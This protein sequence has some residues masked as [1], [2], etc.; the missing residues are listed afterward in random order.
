MIRVYD[1]LSDCID[2]FLE[3]KSDLYRDDPFTL[4]EEK[5]ELVQ[6][7][8]Q[9]IEQDY[10]QARVFLCPGLARMIGFCIPCPN[11]PGKID[12]FFGLWETVNSL[13]V[14]EM[15]FTEL[16]TWAQQQ[17][18]QT[19]VGPIDFTTAHHYRLNL[20][21]GEDRPFYQEPHQKPYYAKLLEIAGYKLQHRYYTW[22]APLEGLA[23]KFKPYVEPI[24][25]TQ[26]REHG[27]RC[28]PLGEYAW[29]DNLHRIRDIA[30]Q[31]FANN[32]NYT[33]FA[34]TYIDQ[35]LN[36]DYF[37]Q[38]CPLSS[39]IALDRHHNLVGFFLAMPDYLEH[40]QQQPTTTTTHY[41]FTTDF[42]PHL[43]NS[44]TT[45]LGKTGGVLPAYRHIGL[46]TVMS[47]LIAQWGSPYYTATGA[48]MVHERNPSAKV[49]SLAFDNNSRREYG[50]YEINFGYR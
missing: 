23:E 20:Q 50:L 41:Q 4:P 10:H 3:V 1:H 13:S 2:E 27:I 45:I 12:V 18:A 21:T 22:L 28:L 49:A 30:K 25:L 31:I 47:Q 48:A 8:D 11:N 42:Q 43:G 36:E 15:L 32:V 14:L 46:F 19:I 6:L 37:L 38:L 35:H 29:R 26:E 33:P 5:E 9:F 17:G 34:D 40:R 39:V 24:R 16:H 7:F 44:N